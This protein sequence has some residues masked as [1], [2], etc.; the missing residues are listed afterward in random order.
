MKKNR[1]FTFKSRN[2]YLKILTLS[3]VLF[4]FSFSVA[5]FS[6]G[7]AYAKQDY[8][9]DM[10]LSINGGIT[11]THLDV[12]SLGTIPNRSGSTINA[13]FGVNIDLSRYGL[14]NFIVGDEIFGGYAN[15]SS[16]S[17]N[18]GNGV[19]NADTRAWYGGG[20]L[21]AGY[22]ISHVIMPFL[23]G[24]Y[25][26]YSYNW[27]FKGPGSSGISVPFTSRA[28]WL[29]GGGVEYNLYK[30]WGVTLQYLGTILRGGSR[31]NNYTLG[32]DYAF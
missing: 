20:D 16:Y 8:F 13:A 4:L 26:G 9:N 2:Y 22:A 5:L 10:Y 19:I 6:A 28:G 24:G 29:Y 15:Y 11:Q 7:N 3:L 32:V 27:S 18:S 31:T 25:I 30:N 14:T 21:K 12:S 17:I 1:D 23:K